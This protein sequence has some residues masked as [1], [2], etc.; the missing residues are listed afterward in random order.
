MITAWRTLMRNWPLMAALAAAAM[1]AIAHGFETFGHLPPC[2]LCLKQRDVYWLALALGVAGFVLARLLRR[3][4]ITPVES[5]ILGLV[6]LLSAGVAGYHAGVEWK[7]WPGPQ[8]CSGS[9]TVGASAIA[10]LLSGARITA[11]RCDQ[12]AWRWLGLS[13]AGWNVLISVGLAA[14]SACAATIGIGDVRR[15]A[16]RARV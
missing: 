12:A 6:F 15:R 4:M 9:T 2:E 10:D 13:M 11:P 5:A 3:P 1:L 14:A 16:V 7:W 8:T